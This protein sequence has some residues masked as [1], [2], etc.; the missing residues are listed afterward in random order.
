[1]WYEPPPPRPHQGT[2]PL[3][4]APARQPLRVAMESEEP[5]RI[6]E[7]RT[8]APRRGTVEVET[9]H[10]QDKVSV[11]LRV[12][13][14]ATDDHIQQG[15]AEMRKPVVLTNDEEGATVL[16]DVDRE[17]HVVI[18]GDHPGIF[19]T[20]G[21]GWH[22][23]ILRNQTVTQ[24][25]VGWIMQNHSTLQKLSTW[26]TTWDPKRLDGEHVFP[27]LA[28]ARMD[29]S[30]TRFFAT[31]ARWIKMAAL[32]RLEVELDIEAGRSKDVVEC[33]VGVLNVVRLSLR[34]V[35]FALGEHYYTNGFDA[36]LT[37]LDQTTIALALT[38][39]PELVTITLNPRQQQNFI[40]DRAFRFSRSSLMEFRRLNATLLAPRSPPTSRGA[41][42]RS[43]I[44]EKDGDHAIWDRVA[45][46][47]VTAEPAVF[48][49][50]DDD[51]DDD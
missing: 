15:L 17:L 33:A 8:D 6:V 12:H 48:E 31:N 21:S 16:L 44:L 49:I 4:S 29:M 39:C 22:Q 36:T 25:T 3:R 46:F 28:E 2:S 51:D 38:R 40:I 24:E 7:V 37:P 14:E 26:R 27:L 19:A 41:L 30:T 50:E 9:V 47:F 5:I 45:R 20:L 13:R 35:T 11:T 42:W 10:A 43:F 23:I 18:E 1:M 32:E 34:H